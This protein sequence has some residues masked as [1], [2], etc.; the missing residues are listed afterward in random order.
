MNSLD[1]GELLKI[2]NEILQGENTGQDL[3]E[4][5]SEKMIEILE[6]LGR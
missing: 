5:V 3:R 4:K 6:V 2:L 1:R